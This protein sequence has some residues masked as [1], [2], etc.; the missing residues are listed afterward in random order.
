M[1]IE[2]T[3]NN[4]KR[5]N[6]EPYFLDSKEE[7]IPLLEKLIGK[8]D[9]VAVGGSE[10]LS[11]LGIID[12]LRNNRNFLDRFAPNLKRDEVMRIFRESFFAD[13][14]ISSS[15][16][17]TENGELYNVDGNGNRIAAI[18]FGPKSVIIIA[19][20]NKIV[21]D[22]DEA[23][24]RVKTIAAPKNC[25]RLDRNTYCSKNGVCVCED[26]KIG[27]GCDSEDRICGTFAVAAKQVIKGRIKVIIVNETIG[28]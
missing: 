6:M 18:T 4:L 14:Y 24:K 9:T 16:A 11:K 1:D 13:A 12:F 19:G 10:T 15:N 7:V 25:V 23:I 8:D 17:I 26:G 5:N 20:I 28:Y 22:T 3:L 2:K 21:K 27:S